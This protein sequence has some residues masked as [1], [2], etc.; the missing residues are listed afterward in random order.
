MMDVLSLD[1][2]L[3]ALRLTDL[4]IEMQRAVFI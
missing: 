3:S 4:M 1:L 2:E